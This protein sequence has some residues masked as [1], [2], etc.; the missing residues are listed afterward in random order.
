M[1]MVPPE[2]I[3]GSN[4]HQANIL[5]YNIKLINHNA[6]SKCKSFSNNKLPMK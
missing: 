4:C 2:N 3:F 5:I 6:S 1:G